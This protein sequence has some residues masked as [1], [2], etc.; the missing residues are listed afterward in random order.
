MNALK[1]EELMELLE[2]VSSVPCSN[3]RTSWATLTY[4]GGEFVKSKSYLLLPLLI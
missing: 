1:S 4:H 2:Q 3:P